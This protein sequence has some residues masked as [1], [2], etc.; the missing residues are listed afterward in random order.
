MLLWSGKEKRGGCISVKKI[1]SQGRYYTGNL[2]QL[3]AR[4]SKLFYD[5]IDFISKRK[6]A[7]RKFL[8]QS[9][10]RRAMQ[11][12][13]Y[14]TVKSVESAGADVVYDISVPGRH[15]FGA[16]G[17]VAHNCEDEAFIQEG[18]MVFDA[19]T[20]RKIESQIRPV[21]WQGDLIDK[22]G[23]VGLEPW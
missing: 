3:A 20:L 8:E 15:C 22:G 12:L 10:G 14:D 17:I 2:M 11:I 9:S 5:Q 23:R 4:N 1:N 19:Q 6:R 7:G 21:K 13:D 16:N 18:I